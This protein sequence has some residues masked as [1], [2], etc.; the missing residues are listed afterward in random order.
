MQT[1]ALHHAGVDII[2]R[3]IVQL[4]LTAKKVRH[5]LFG[6]KAK[7]DTSRLFIYLKQL[8]SAIYFIV[9][10][11]CLS[12]ASISHATPIIQEPNFQRLS[13]ANGL[14]QDTVNTLV[15]D[16]EGFLW[17]GTEAGLNRYDGYQTIQVKGPNNEF[18]DMPVSYLFQDSRGNM[19]V[20]ES[21]GGIH[22]Y[23]L[24]SNRSKL[25]ISK[26]YTTDPE[27]I[28]VASKITE[29]AD[30]DIW[31]SLD[32]SLVKYSYDTQT[33]SKA[34]SLPTEKLGTEIV[35]SHLV[36]PDFLF[37]GSS[38]GLIAIDRKTKVQTEIVFLADENKSV[39]N[40]NVKTLVTDQFDNVWIGTVEG[41][42]RMPLSEL[43]YSL[44][45]KQPA[46]FAEE[47][48]KDRNIWAISGDETGLLHIV[49]DLGYYQLNPVDNKVEQIFLP[50]DSRYT[51]S[52]DTLKSVVIDNN[53]NLWIGS[54]ND[55]A[56]YWT[57]YTT[58]FKNVLNLFGGRGAK[59]FTDNNVWSL[60][61]QDAETLW[62]GTKNGLNKYN[63]LTGET[64]QFLESEDTKAQYSGSS[65]LNIH[66]AGDGTLWLQTND[67]LIKFDT[68]TNT[69]LPIIANNEVDQA[70]LEVYLWSSYLADNGDLMLIT[71]KRFLR[72]SPSSNEVQD[73]ETLSAFI[74]H[75]ETVGF[76][77]SGK[78]GAYW[79]SVYGELWAM[80]ETNDTLTLVHR[81][82]SE[83]KKARV[84]PSD[85]ILDDNNILWVAYPS[86]GLF[87]L[88]A[89]TYEQKYFFDKSNVLPTNVIFDLN[90]D[91]N[92]NIWMASNTGLLRL[93]TDNLQLER[94]DQ[95]SGLTNSD[96]NFD[97]STVLY[98][99]RMVYGSPK[100]ITI[101]NPQNIEPASI[102]HQE[103]T[104]TNVT[105][106]T[107]PLDLPFK[108]LNN[109]VVELAHDDVGLNISFSTL[110][111]ENQQNV[112][113]QY[114]LRGNE[115]IV[116][117]TTTSSSIM[118]PRL[119]PGSY[120]FVVA[121]FDAQNDNFFKPASL[122]IV[123]AYPPFLS[124]FA[125]A[126]YVTFFLLL[127]SV[128]WK[129]KRK[130][131]QALAIAHQQTLE[132]NDKLKLA[133]SA[134]N[135]GVWEY[136]INNDLFW[137]NKLYSSTTQLITKSF[138]EQLALVNPSDKKRFESAW[139]HFIKTPNVE[140]DITYRMLSKQ[141]Q[142]Y[143]FRDVGKKVKFDDS[144][145][146]TVVT[147][148]YTNV[149]RSMVDKGNLR[150]F[151]EAFK[152][153]LDWVIIYDSDYHV[154][155]CNDAFKT[156]LKLEGDSDAA[157]KLSSILESQPDNAGKTWK[158]IRTLKAGEH[159]KGEDKLLLPD[160]TLCDVLMHINA[161]PNE[162]QKDK[163]EHVLV[164]ISD[165]TEQKSAEAKLRI[166]ANYD[167]LTGLPNRTLLLDRINRAIEH[168]QRVER[169]LAVF[170][171]DLDKFKQVNDSLG[172]K[173][174]DALLKVVAERLSRK[175]RKED[176]VARLGGDEFVIMIEEVE[177]IE[178]IS[179]LVS[180][181]SASIDLP[182][183]LGSQS[184]SV[185]SSI[186][187]SLF[188][189]DGKTADELLKNADIAMY[190]AKEKGRSNFQFFTQQM[191]ELV[192]RRL[193]LENELKDAHKA[194]VF[195]NHYQPII[196]TQSKR[197]EGFEILM[198]WESNGEMIPPDIF[199]PVS[200]EL[201][202]IESMTL[203]AIERAMPILKTLQ[204]DGFDGYMSFNL[205]AKH[206][207]NQSSI[208]LIIA[209]L[210]KNNIPV[211]A[212]RFEI[213]ESALMRDYDSALKYMSYLRKK[214]FVIALDDFGTG[215]SSLKYLKEFPINI[216]KI[217]K[218]FTDD[219]GKNKNNEAIILTTLSMAQQLS[220]SCIAE[221]IETL[222][223]VEFFNQH[224][225]QHL[226]GYYFSRPVPGEQAIALLEKTWG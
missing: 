133:L 165:I 217:D 226:Q 154:V 94:F 76:K 63:L 68:K 60:H 169:N 211:D 61:Q 175:V 101:F 114:E 95:N 98:D 57:Q 164:I 8:K 178:D 167:A 14:S 24:G 19:W 189:G 152:H 81:L 212:I 88:D 58:E 186:G 92:G 176:T 173:A 109:Q 158:K 51:I 121:K 56:I 110:Q 65:I 125:Y 179:H 74:N 82:D 193:E 105:L 84:Y 137:V 159:W 205:S 144:G 7:S 210:E 5:Y 85:V 28:Q 191:D 97:A 48:I 188:P 129:Y 115:D 120:E 41:L 53:N 32:Q 80:D 93:S 161:V 216:I 148:T 162:L 11:F 106:S 151:G 55:G 66:P 100:G 49:T 118:F 142:W 119:E 75:H 122:N 134:S 30:G 143:W 78:E 187:V 123:V 50:T 141:G 9:V 215:Y 194:K 62:V 221:G 87:G 37:V 190:H 195:Q 69:S 17:L 39:D 140:L 40:Q 73:L 184:V 15:L 72:Y 214:G 64:Q 147:G 44:N 96:F 138:D 170:F 29:D 225:C 157:S 145:T 102:K 70:K 79:V 197:I 27:Y 135:S 89:T 42:Y 156:K 136:D 18:V 111:Y 180:Q 6:R 146:P 199:I 38:Y 108:A 174:G 192:K 91:Q 21:V 1:R 218:S 160:N 200:E 112:K 196:N 12:Y 2:K 90:T 201:G 132:S 166:L 183:S 182:I 77:P 213:T 124:P 31:F 149:T 177:S 168:A 126:L 52:N 130:Q 103:T 13:T 23:D 4:R 22:Q 86:L 59:V 107:N 223:H 113:Y 46:P 185:S 224:N 150:L 83:H 139:K 171:I 203:D 117:P 25:V 71:D 202:L 43:V 153:T 35:R 127:L 131:N 47:T 99:G 67:G 172:H 34:F 16:N 222:Q 220:M 128:L 116:Y 33:I 181:I 54:G 155:A 198:R 163:I 206:F 204:K 3:N 208:Y 36:L 209:A 10:S 104:I 45:Q 219:I 20:S 207:E 26:P